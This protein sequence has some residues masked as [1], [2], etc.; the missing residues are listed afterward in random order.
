MN[1][2]KKKIQGLKFF[3]I[4]EFDRA[5]QVFGA[6]INLYF[7]RY[8]RPE[9]PRQYEDMANELMF[10]GGRLP[11]MQPEVDRDKA[12]AMVSALLRS[13]APAHEA[14]T[15]TVAYALWL[16]VEGDLA[17]KGTEGSDVS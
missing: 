6:D 11:E 2:P 5:A 10:K 7:P 16:W 8:D 1:K 3:P 4:P 12:T 14:K 9:V 15:T 17:D 13:F